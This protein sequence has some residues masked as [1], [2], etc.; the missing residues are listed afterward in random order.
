LEG[1]S[2]TSYGDDPGNRQAGEETLIMTGYV[3]QSRDRAAGYRTGLFPRLLSLAG[4]ALSMHTAWLGGKLVQEYGEA[5]KPVMDQQEAEKGQ[6]EAG[7]S[8]SHQERGRN[9]PRGRRQES[10]ASRNG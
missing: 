2:P 5:V 9:G 7:S 1:L 4:G 10:L 6:L 3:L 8:G